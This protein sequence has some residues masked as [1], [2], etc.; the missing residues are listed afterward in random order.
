MSNNNKWR[1]DKM[2]EQTAKVVSIQRGYAWVLPAKAG[3]CGSCKSEKNCSSDGLF[4][5]MKPAAEKMYVANPLHAKPG[6]EV[7]IGMQG[8]ALLMYSVFAYLLPL[9]SMIAFAF[10]G[11]ELFS[12]LNLHADAGAVLAGVCGL[13]SG[14]RLASWLASH[15]ARSEN[16]K[17]VILRHK[18]Q[19]I[20]PILPVA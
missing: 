15:I 8:N 1:D 20:Q 6:D 7:V 5:F 17:P 12:A 14:L 13:L 16:A 2:I 18:E 4:D 10:L 11:K 3:Y 9:L 19:I